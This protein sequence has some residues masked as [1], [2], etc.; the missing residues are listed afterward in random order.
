M[1]CKINHMNSIFTIIMGTFM[2]MGI[3]IK[4]NIFPNLL[5]LIENVSA[6]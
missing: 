6:D 4:N 2:M 5:N 1:E 3:L